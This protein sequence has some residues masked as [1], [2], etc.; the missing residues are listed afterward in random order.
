MALGQDHSCVK[1]DDGELSRNMEDGLNDVF[2]YF[3]FGVV[4][5]RGVV[6]GEGC[7]VVSVINVARRAVVMMPKAEGN[8]RVGLIVIV[9]LD[10][11]FDAA[12]RGEIG[13]SETVCWKRAFPT[14]D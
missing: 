8:S 14:G 6:P 7:A 1:A 12:V 11:Y 4:K 10:F 2:A 9:V 13:T 3:G 5:L